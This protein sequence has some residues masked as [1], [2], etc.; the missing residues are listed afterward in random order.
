MRKKIPL[1]LLACL[2]LSQFS[3]SQCNSF[4]KKK[5]IPSLKPYVHNGLNNSASLL[6]GEHIQLLMTFNP[7]QDYRIMV[8]AEE[9]L[10]QVQF[11]LVDEKKKIIFASKDHSNTNMWDFNVKTSQQIT[12]E[13]TAPPSNSPHHKS[14][15]VSVVVGSMK[16]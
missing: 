4:N 14:G 8:C 1:I 13:V 2:G 7:G 3:F 6:T 5:C 9:A 15:C 11:K 10:G 16:K 12:V